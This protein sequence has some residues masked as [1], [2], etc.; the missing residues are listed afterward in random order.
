LI[1]RVGVE[2]LK[3]KHRQAKVTG[4]QKKTRVGYKAQIA[5]SLPEKD[6]LNQNRVITSIVTQR[7]NESD[8]PGLVAVLIGAL[9]R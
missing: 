4:K 8:E 7:A 2:V 3:N 5:E 6:A 1:R 9:P